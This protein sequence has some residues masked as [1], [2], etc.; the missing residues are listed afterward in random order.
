MLIVRVGFNT[1]RGRKHC[2]PQA[3][4]HSLLPG[5]SSLQVGQPSSLRGRLGCARLFVM[6]LTMA[7]S[8][9]LVLQR[10]CLASLCCKTPLDFRNL[11]KCV[12]SNVHNT[13]SV[14]QPLCS[15]CLLLHQR[16]TRTGT[17]PILTPALPPPSHSTSLHLPGIGLLQQAQER[18]E[19]LVDTLLTEF[20]NGNHSHALAIV[21]QMS[22]TLC[23]RLDLCEFVLQVRTYSG[24]EVETSRGR[25]RQREE[26]AFKGERIFTNV[27]T[28][29]HTHT[30]T[31][32]TRRS[33]SRCHFSCLLTTTLGAPKRSIPA[34]SWRHA[35]SIGW[36]HGEA[37]HNRRCVHAVLCMGCGRMV[38]VFVCV[39][40]LSHHHD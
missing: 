32:H 2:M 8:R 39:C 23:K 6:S 29:T 10:A 22:H 25:E 5:D 9:Q 35:V 18:C 38:C 12:S 15:T 16:V 21:D 33:V 24:R 28:H 7:S 1:K 40:L 27:N 34:G 4:P 31:H 37:E 19:R 36:I 14:S 20:R 3:R 11:S 17:A 13:S 26:H 30:H